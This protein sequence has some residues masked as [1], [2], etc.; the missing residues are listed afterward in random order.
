MGLAHVPAAFAFLPLLLLRKQK[1]QLKE[2]TMKAAVAL[3]RP[4]L[5]IL[6]DALVLQQLNAASGLPPLLFS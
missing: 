3:S 6:I 5:G 4:A 2:K 1:Q